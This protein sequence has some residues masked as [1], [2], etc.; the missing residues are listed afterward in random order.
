MSHISLTYHIVW[1]TKYSQATICEE[2]EI[3]L[4]RYITG[5]CTNKKS[6]LYRI[7]SMPDHVH[8][9][10]EITPTIAISEFMQVLKQETSK[11]M[12]THP[13]W[14][15]DFQAWGN[16]YAA[17]GYSAKERPGIIRYIMNQKNHHK[18]SNLKDEYE[19]LMNDFGLDAST[20]LFLK[21]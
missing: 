14:F 20:D 15:P 8:I 21:D 11:W 5:I 9:C 16:G 6:K 2:H 1:R 17:F 12:K 10:V 7:N 13:E 19:K 4:Y 18:K 3:E